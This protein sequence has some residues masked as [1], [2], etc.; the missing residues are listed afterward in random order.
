MQSVSGAL[1]FADDYGVD[2][3]AK[4]GI[5]TSAVPG[6]ID[7]E[8][9][10]E[11]AVFGLLTGVTMAPLIIANVWTILSVIITATR[12]FRYSKWLGRI[13]QVVLWVF[14]TVFSASSTTWFQQVSNNC[15]VVARQVFVVRR[16]RCERGRPLGRR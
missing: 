15:N 1:G 16:R 12:F 4:L 10:R 11:D 7:V 6:G 2:A 8:G 3:D 5:D 13:V 14:G 9:L